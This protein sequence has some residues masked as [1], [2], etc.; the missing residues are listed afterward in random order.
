M[1]SRQ[2]P[3]TLIP[4]KVDYIFEAPIKGIYLLRSPERSDNRGVFHQVY[5]H[6]DFRDASG[7]DF[8]PVQMN[9]STS[10]RK[11]IRALHAEPWNKLVYPATGIMYAALLDIRPD[12]KTFGQYC[13]F[14]FGDSDR[15][16]LYVPKGVANSICVTGNSDVDYIYLVD[17]EYTGKPTRGIAWNDPD[18][19]IPWPIV[20]PVMSDSDS[21]H[22][23]LGDL[24]KNG[25]L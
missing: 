25:L 24:I 17:E 20:D 6:S 1:N 2:I 12:S 23:P 4:T 8:R 14:T 10:H 5:R 22:P 21:K 16:G 18:L 13:A 3:L 11:V 9:R 7:I 19:S 15:Y